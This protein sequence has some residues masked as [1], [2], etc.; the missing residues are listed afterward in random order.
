MRVQDPGEYQR[1]IREDTE[2]DV[3]VTQCVEPATG[4]TLEVRE[5]GFHS[6]ALGEH[7]EAWVGLGYGP[8][9]PGPA[10]AWTASGLGG[11]GLDPPRE[12]AQ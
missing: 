3:V 12:A 4:L 10:R 1:L 9:C 6:F 7:R 8:Q 11:E 5:S 2:S